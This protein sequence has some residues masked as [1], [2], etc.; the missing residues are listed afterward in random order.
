M[1]QHCNHNEDCENIE[2]AICS[3]DKKCV[4]E[5]QYVAFGSN[6]CLGL[7][8]EFCRK[9]VDCFFHKSVV[10]VDNKCQ[11]PHNYLPLLSKDQCEP[12]KE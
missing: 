1:Q 2:F 7:I 9:N 3:N 10:C 11:C 5:S 4:C 8:G 6:K 12:G